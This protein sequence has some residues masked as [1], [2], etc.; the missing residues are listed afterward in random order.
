MV[1]G[2]SNGYAML[3]LRTPPQ[4]MREMYKSNYELV[5]LMAKSEVEQP[6]LE[7]LNAILAGKTGIVC[8]SVLEEF[9]GGVSKCG[10]PVERNT[11]KE[12]EKTLVVVPDNP[13][14]RVMSSLP[15]TTKVDPK[16]KIIFGTG[17]HWRAPTLTAKKMVVRAI[18]QTGMSLLTI[19]HRHRALNGV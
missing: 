18:A 17:D 10:G 16:N 11:A 9:K 7:E 2:I 3:L 12:L 19:V 13:S 15:A 6:I 4:K 1:S 5:I 8:Q 14:E